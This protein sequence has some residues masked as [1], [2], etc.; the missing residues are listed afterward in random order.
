MLKP[1]TKDSCVRRI[2]YRVDRSSSRHPC[3]LRVWPF[4]RKRQHALIPHR[5]GGIMVSV[6]TSSAVDR[7]FK[8]RSGQSK[9]YRI[10]IC[11]FSAKHTVLRTKSKDQFAWNLDNV[12]EWGGMPTHR[13]L[14]QCT[15]TI[16]IQLSVLVWYK[17]D[18]IIISLIINFF[19]LWYSRNIARQQ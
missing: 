17:A 13:L 14:F 9:D 8:S 5:I 6:V 16:K 2:I 15:S 3:V 11:C 18:L 7:G 10:G 1:L 12:S 19:W 4:V